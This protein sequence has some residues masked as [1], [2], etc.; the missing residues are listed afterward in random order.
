MHTGL[1]HKQVAGHRLFLRRR[2]SGEDGEPYG[3]KPAIIRR[4]VAGFQAPAGLSGPDRAN[5][6]GS[7]LFSR[8]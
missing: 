8:P 3:L 1:R 6:F 4:V 2:A 7:P 5:P